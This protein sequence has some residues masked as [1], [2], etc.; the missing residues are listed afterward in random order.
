MGKIKR[1]T[2]SEKD[3][4]G[5]IPLYL[6]KKAQ[7]LDSLFQKVQDV[8]LQKIE[9]RVTRNQLEQMEGASKTAVREL[10]RKIVKLKKCNVFVCPCGQGY[11]YNIVGDPTPDKK[12]KSRSGFRQLN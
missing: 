8:P 4:Q 12:I 5:I 2:I 10:M 3:V 1:I 11:L 9:W 6:S 7:R